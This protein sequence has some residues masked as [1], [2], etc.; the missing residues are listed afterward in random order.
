MKTGLPGLIPRPL[1]DFIS[2]LQDK[3]WEWPGTR[4]W[5]SKVDPT[6]T[7]LVAH[8]VFLQSAIDQHG[9][10]LS[11]RLQQCVGNGVVRLLGSLSPV[12]LIIHARSS[13]GDD[14]LGVI[15]VKLFSAPCV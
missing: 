14:G 15:W 1:Q 6:E 13:L 12:V 8:L 10:L 3:T 7:H 4:L 5:T 9:W 11:H 2:Q